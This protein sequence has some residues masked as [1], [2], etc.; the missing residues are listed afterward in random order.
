[1]PGHDNRHIGRI[2]HWGR[3][4][5][6]VDAFCGGDA[7][8]SPQC[9][10]PSAPADRIIRAALDAPHGAP[11][12]R[13]LARG[14]RSA[15]ILV[16][17]QD[18]VAAADVFLPLL[19]DDLHAAGLPDER[20]EIILATGTH[21]SHS[22]A[23]AERLLGADVVR[24]VRWR[25]HECEGGDGL[26][27]LGVTSRGTEIAFDRAATQADLVILTG[28]V[29]PHYFA[30]FGGGRKA[31]LPGIAARSTIVQNHR[32]TL[33]PERG[34]H[35]AV[36]CASLRG[37]PVH[38][39]MVEAARRVANTFVL[40]TLLDERHRVVAAVAG[41][42]ETAH[43]EGCR[44]AGE[45][46]CLRMDEPCDALVSSAGGWPCDCDY[47]QAL[48]TAF[49]VRDAVREGGALLW[50]AEATNG[51]R[52]SFL[53][54]THVADDEALEAAVRAR[55]DLSGHNSILLR[56]LTRRLR[57]ALFSAL[58]DA[59]VA[60]LGLTPVHSLA[61]GLRWL[62]ERT[63]AGGRRAWVPCAN[64][65]HVTAAPPGVTP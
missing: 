2:L 37:N 11:P 16:P 30:G 54:W 59:Q 17:G 46:L 44:L 5:F 1:M 27:P 12:L 61:E 28:R 26:A 48:K 15:V 3:Q 45:W 25:Q 6:P 52:P 23:E 13:E 55:Y 49:N 34:L 21:T 20:I 18:R 31:L 41:E 62:D 9:P 39:D 19:L 36:R 24:R 35:P 57:V 43:N 4:S 53:Q 63:P 65:T 50:V 38:E 58:P 64:I 7:W 60:A 14:R 29:I 40:N 51:I 56:Q 8:L 47:V 32:L 10:T 33:A 42:L 22:K